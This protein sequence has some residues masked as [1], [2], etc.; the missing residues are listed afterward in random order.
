MNRQ[1]AH[2]TLIRLLPQ[3]EA[4]E[5]VNVGVVLAVPARGEFEFRLLRPVGRVTHFF[6]E[7]TATLLRQVRDDV[8]LELARLRDRVAAGHDALL[9][10]AELCRPREALIRYAPPRTLFCG[11]TKAALDQ[12]MTRFV[13]RDAEEVQRRREALLN[14]QVRR[15][16]GELKLAKAFTDEQLGN[17]QFHV[18]LPFVHRAGGVTRAVIKPLDLALDEPQKIFDHVDP[19]IQKLKRLR[20]IDA[21][22]WALVIP[23][24]ATTEDTSCRAAAQEVMDELQRE[25]RALLV[26]VNDVDRFTALVREH[27]SE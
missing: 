25:T 5:F 16:L 12:L 4:G 7:F 14:R 24:D 11:E 17:D 10:L 13:E 1:V 20:R 18:R 8:R 23:T 9:V 27:V 21:A 2:Y 26:D 6:P 19:W 22:P 3:A 15:T